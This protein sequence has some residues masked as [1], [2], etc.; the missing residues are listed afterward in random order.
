[1]TARKAAVTTSRITIRTNSSRSGFTLIELLLVMVIIGVVMGVSIPRY[2]GSFEFMKLK[3]CSYDVAATIEHAQ[4]L[5]VLDERFVRLNFSDEGDEC[6]L[7][8]RRGW[9]RDEPFD[10][11]EYEF[12]T[13]VVLLKIEFEDPFRAMSRYVDFNPDGRFD[14]CTITLS[15]SEGDTYLIDVES[16]LGRVRVNRGARKIQ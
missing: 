9:A 11:V 14:N 13:G 16:G 12:A 2:K 5:A 3:S 1:M 6:F 10:P 15:N 8:E 7:T 4:A